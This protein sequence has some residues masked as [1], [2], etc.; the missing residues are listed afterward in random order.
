MSCVPSDETVVGTENSLARRFAGEFIVDSL[1]FKATLFGATYRYPGGASE[2][3]ERKFP[4][5]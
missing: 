1:S 3:Y 5:N 2:Q 4:R